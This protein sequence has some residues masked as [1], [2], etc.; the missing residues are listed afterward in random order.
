MASKLRVDHIEPTNGIPTGGGGGIIQLVSATKT[1]TQS[2][3]SDAK[4]DI[5]GLSV[6]ITPHSTASKLYITGNVIIGNSYDVCCNI[7]IDA[8]GTEIGQGDADGSRTRAHTGINYDDNAENKYQTKSVAVNYLYSPNSTSAQTIK[9]QM[10]E[11]DGT[12]HASNNK[13]YINRSFTE[14]D[15]AW[16]ARY[17]STLTVMEVSG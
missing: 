15:A 1:D 4:T 10:S 11:T 13:M 16:C 7:H 14:T 5:T 3:H 17:V 12:N 8:N 6:T 2:T 9:L